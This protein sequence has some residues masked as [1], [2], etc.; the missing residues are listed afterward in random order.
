LARRVLR[1]F[2][3]TVTDSFALPAPRSRARPV[4]FSGIFNAILPARFD[5]VVFFPRTVLPDFTIAVSLVRLSAVLSVQRRPELRTE[6]SDCFL[7][8][9]SLLA[10]GGRNV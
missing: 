3:V 5:L 7:G 6:V 2:A 4:A 10:A 1:L 8:I 9:A